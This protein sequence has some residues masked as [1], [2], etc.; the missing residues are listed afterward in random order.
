V[1]RPG[2]RQETIVSYLGDLD[3][4]H[5]D[6]NEIEIEVEEYN[7]ERSLIREHGQELLQDLDTDRIR[8]VLGR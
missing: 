4:E 6:D 2:D 5:G 8:S 1:P 7:P 3:V